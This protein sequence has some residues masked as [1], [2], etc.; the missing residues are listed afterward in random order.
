MAKF[1]VRNTTE[2][3]ITVII[4]HDAEDS[5]CGDGL[6]FCLS[7][8][9]TVAVRIEDSDGDMVLIKDRAHAEN[10][11]KALNKAIDL[12]WFK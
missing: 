7:Q 1:D 8:G 12:G 3:E 2:E 6:A 9:L 4:F 11:I 10:L 5:S